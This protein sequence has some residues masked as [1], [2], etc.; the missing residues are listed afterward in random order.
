MNLNE[1]QLLD[2]LRN[3]DRTAQKTLYTKYVGSLAAICS[4]YVVDPD[5]VKDVLQESFIKIFT[6]LD[7]FTYRG[8]GSLK[9]WMGRI[10]VNMSIN[11]I[12]TSGRLNLV[13]D[14][15]VSANIAETEEPDAEECHR[16]CCRR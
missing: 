10:V 4:R 2:Q 15:D 11:F 8:E 14:D 3:G 5:D 1:Q 12:K 7:S 16:E 6:Q 13:Y 9:A